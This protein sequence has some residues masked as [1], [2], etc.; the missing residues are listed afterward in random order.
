MLI[1]DFSCILLNAFVLNQ[2][3]TSVELILSTSQV[4]H[5]FIVSY[6]GCF[7]NFLY[8]DLPIDP[9]RRIKR[10]DWRKKTLLWRNDFLGT[11]NL[12]WYIFI[13]CLC[14]LLLIFKAKYFLCFAFVCM[15]FGLPSPA[16]H[17]KSFV[18]FLFRLKVIF[19]F[20]LYVLWFTF[21]SFPLFFWHVLFF[22]GYIYICICF[23]VCFFLTPCFANHMFDPN[24]AA[25]EFGT[26]HFSHDRRIIVT[27]K[28]FQTST[29]NSP[30]ILQATTRACHSGKCSPGF[31][32]SII[33]VHCRAIPSLCQLKHHMKLGFQD[34][35]KTVC[36]Y[37]FFQEL[38]LQQKWL[39]SPLETWDVERVSV[40]T[41]I[42]ALVQI[43]H[44]PLHSTVQS[45]GL[46]TVLLHQLFCKP[47]QRSGLSSFDLQLRWHWRMLESFLQ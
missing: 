44:S 17:W 32:I 37:S 14:F 26:L 21:L 15:C 34:P 8:R 39:H 27:A 3:T 1:V 24:F 31:F 23:M 5:K 7:S 38:I 36:S 6:K 33:P 25:A 30:G 10:V 2:K 45:L 4:H 11:K 29:A 43:N 16:S 9:C 28:H 22:Q 13:F 19:C 42:M 40:Q 12:C 35:Q 20:C 18:T 41:Q 47:N 46:I